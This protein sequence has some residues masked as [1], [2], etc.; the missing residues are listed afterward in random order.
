MTA[1]TLGSASQTALEGDAQ[2][3]IWAQS[4]IREVPKAALAKWSQRGTRQGRGSLACHRVKLDST[5]QAIA[6][7]DKRPRWGVLGTTEK[8]SDDVHNWRCRGMS[9]NLEMNTCA[10]A[11]ALPRRY[12]GPVKL[13]QELQSFWKTVL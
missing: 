1:G 9:V 7:K 12:L 4:G 11:R 8:V 10:T 13:L 2:R 5:E 6:L 3:R